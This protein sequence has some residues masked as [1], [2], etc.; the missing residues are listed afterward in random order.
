MSYFSDIH[1]VLL[2]V[3]IFLGAYCL[4]SFKNIVNAPSEQKR[5]RL[6]IFVFTLVVFV[7]LMAV[8][9]LYRSSTGLLR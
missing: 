3:T 2:V 1:A 6:R 7:L 5:Q 9:I 8:Q 4:L